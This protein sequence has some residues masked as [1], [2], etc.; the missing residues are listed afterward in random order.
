MDVTSINT[1]VS[2]H[3]DV[4]DVAAAC[5][6]LRQ[7]PAY[8]LSPT[9]ATYRPLFVEA[10]RRADG[11]PLALQLWQHLRRS[12]VSPDLDSVHGFIGAVMQLSD[13]GALPPLPRAT[14]A[15]HLHSPLSPTI[16]RYCD[17]HCHCHLDDDLM[18]HLQED[19]E[20]PFEPT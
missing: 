17:L 5:G 7:L 16:C 14:A 11:G 6:L 1:V 12:G 9:A 18:A 13:P 3:C 8:G 19:F 4:G 15:G 20:D 2:M 10:P